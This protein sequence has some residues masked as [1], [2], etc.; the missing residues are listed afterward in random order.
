MGRVLVCNPVS[1]NRRAAARAREL[2]LDHGYD[3]RDTSGPGD[4]VDIARRAATEGADLVVACGGDGTVN[5]VVRGVDAAG[6]LADVR[7]GVVPT[8]TGNGFAE[9]VGIT[10]VRDAFEA[11]ESGTVRSLDLG[12]AD[13]R[14]FLKTC[15]SGIPAAVSAHTTPDMKRY[16]GLSAYGLGALPSALDSLQGRNGEALPR[17]R[18][19]LGEPNDPTWAGTAVLLLVG[20]SRR[21][22]GLVFRQA[23]M[24]DGL[25]EAVVVKRP[26]V[27]GA[28]RRTDESATSFDAP[29]LLRTRTSQLTVEAPAPTPFSLDGEI[30][31]RSSV[32][33]GIRSGALRFHVGEGY[34]PR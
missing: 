1:G 3:V 32:R 12:T 11:V 4:A 29:S 34:R 24:E 10:G 7:L 30:Y 28:I 16:F 2:A 19:R 18:V 26:S 27:L 21:F 15:V 6:A 8:G 17:L 9:D 22:P 23:P 5:E 14:F 25:L 13:D 33:I 20:N 31:R